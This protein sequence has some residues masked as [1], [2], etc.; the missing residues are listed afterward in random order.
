MG[1]QSGGIKS[2]ARTLAQT[3]QNPGAKRRTQ[4]HQDPTHR[5]SFQKYSSCCDQKRCKGLSHLA[6]T[7][8]PFKARHGSRHHPLHC[9][10]FGNRQVLR[11]KKMTNQYTGGV[12]KATGR[13]TL[14]WQKKHT[15]KM[16]KLPSLLYS[17]QTL[18]EAAVRERLGI[19]VKRSN[20]LVVQGMK[21]PWQEKCVRNRGVSGDSV[22]PDCWANETE[23]LQLHTLPGSPNEI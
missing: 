11:K 7:W 1:Q 10:R 2:L 3:P 16:V 5:T 4:D 8:W 22:H 9:T 15:R 14:K 18:E 17:H 21:N 23:P 13:W 20:R 12:L 6:Y 19:Y